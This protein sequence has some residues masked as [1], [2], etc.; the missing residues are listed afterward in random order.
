[1]KPG[2]RGEFVRVVKAQ[3]ENDGKL[4]WKLP[5]N[6]EPGNG[7]QF[8]IQS[9]AVPAIDDIGNNSFT[10]VQAPDE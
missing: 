6:L 8:Y 2:Q 1:M 10:V 9:V 7:Y 3:T 5:K 4:N